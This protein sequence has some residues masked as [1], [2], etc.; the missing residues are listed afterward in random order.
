MHYTHLT[1]H[2]KESFSDSMF[3]DDLVP[4]NHCTIHNNKRKT[5][6]KA[7]TKLLRVAATNSATELN[8]EG[9]QASIY[10]ERTEGNIFKRPPCTAGFY[11]SM[12]FRFCCYSGK[13]I[14]F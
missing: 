9:I 6:E 12:W 11:Q 3:Q 7:T 14:L 4:M 1:S 10:I 8:K 2:T 5:K 13:L